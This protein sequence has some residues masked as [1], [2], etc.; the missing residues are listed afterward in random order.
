MKAT[1]AELNRKIETLEGDL[2]SK[3]EAES[4]YNKERDLIRSKVD[5]L[6]DKLDGVQEPHHS[7]P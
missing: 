1:N 2:Q 3:I 5:G 4:S 6:L 7:D